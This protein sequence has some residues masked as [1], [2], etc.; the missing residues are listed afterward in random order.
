VRLGRGEGDDRGRHVV[1]VGRRIGDAQLEGAAA[2][3]SAE[4]HCDQAHEAFA[5]L[6]GR[7]NDQLEQLDQTIQTGLPALNQAI[8]GA[9]VGAIALAPERAAGVADAAPDGVSGTLSREGAGEGGAPPEA[10]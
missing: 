7:I 8:A 4:R 3:A 10:C 2:A 9:G 6:A 5:Y 1:G